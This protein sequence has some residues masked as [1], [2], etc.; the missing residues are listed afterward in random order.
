M[1]KSHLL[2]VGAVLSLACLMIFALA[3]TASAD[4]EVMSLTDLINKASTI[5]HGKVSKAEAYWNKDQTMIYTTVNVSVESYLKGGSAT[6]DVTI[7][8]PGGTVGDITLWVSDTPVFEE[9]QEVIL[10]L[11]EEYFQIVGWFQGKFTIVDDMVVE[12][13]MRTDQFTG[14]VK[15]VLEGSASP[16]GLSSVP[17]KS[18][19]ETLKEFGLSL[20]GL[21]EKESDVD[22][23][24]RGAV[25]ALAAETCPPTMNDFY[26]GIKWPG[27]CPTLDH[28]IYENT[29][30]TTGEGAAIQAAASTWTNVSGSC[31][32]FN[33]AGA[34][35]RS[36]PTYDGH[37]VLRW[38][39]TGG[40]IATNYVWYSGSNILES[41]VVF[42]DGFNWS[43][44]PSPPPDRMDV[45]NIATHELGHSLLLVDLYQSC[46]SDVTMYG[47]GANGETKKRTLDP[48]DE[49]GI[50]YIYPGGGPPPSTSTPTPTATP[51]PT[52]TQTAT[53]TPT[54][55][56]TAT[57]TP[58]P[59]PT[60]TSTPCILFG[61]FD[62]NGVVDVLDIQEV[63]SRWNTSV[64]DPDYDPTY[65]LDSDGDIDVVD[66][67]IVSGQWGA[68]C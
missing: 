60:A 11:R 32:I 45:Q 31:F 13:G 53:P 54:P 40:S 6:R 17:K 64:G 49:D 42:N 9:G 65:D 46:N 57:P 23:Q 7:E 25:A 62:E 52:P 5:L 36:A 26:G 2:K 34:T 48:S 18:F 19:I 38:G 28:E 15:A 58:T 59:T 1:G 3:G 56:P 41:D 29:A 68:T 16:D 67:M 44:D 8:V 22:T 27:S 12:K 43:A 24:Y 51:T 50:R 35:T 4:V 55:T 47:Y 63:A 61:D 21:S 14:Y 10:F 39:S 20:L 30:D 37:N 33:Y 66:I